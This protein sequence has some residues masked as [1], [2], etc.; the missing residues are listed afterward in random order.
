MSGLL[1]APQP[2]TVIAI[3]LSA[4]SEPARS[5][6]TELLGGTVIEP[7]RLAQE[8][9]LLADRSEIAEEIVRLTIHIDALEK[10][11]RAGGE[12]GKRID[13]LLQEMQR[14]VNTMLSKT[15]N[16]EITRLGIAIKADIEKLREQVQNVE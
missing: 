5:R 15:G 10:L 3:G 7:A 8:V 12:V 14:E 9:A 6:F 16:L 4:G 2:A 11:L 13:F 1:G